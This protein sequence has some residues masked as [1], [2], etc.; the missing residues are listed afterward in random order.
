MH[1][2]QRCHKVGRL[3]AMSMPLLVKFLTISISGCLAFAPSR[4]FLRPSFKHVVA[5][6][7]CMLHA[8]STN[9]DEYDVVIIGAGVG[10]LSCAALCSKYGLKTLCL[11]AHD[12][13]GGAAHSFSRYSSASKTTPFRFDSGPSLMTGLSSKGTNPLRQVLDAIGTADT[14]DWRTYDGWLVHD[15]ADS[16]TFKLTTGDGGKGA[17]YHLRVLL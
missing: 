16:T 2:E 3:A 17:I 13:P 15:L 6:D 4:L 12:T 5:S 10:G 14:I 11:E 7:P 1:A 9:D 8:S